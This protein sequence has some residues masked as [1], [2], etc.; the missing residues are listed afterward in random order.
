MKDT[1]GRISMH[2]FHGYKLN[3]SYVLRSLWVSL[4]ISSLAS[5]VG[6]SSGG[7]G[8]GGTP[9]SPPTPGLVGPW[10]GSISSSFAGNGTIA[11]D[12][13]SEIVRTMD[14]I[15]SVERGYASTL[16]GFWTA[17]F[18]G[19]INDNGGTFTG[20]SLD[21]MI[22]GTLSSLNGCPATINATV[23]EFTVEGTFSA[24]DCT[25]VDNGSFILAKQSEE[26]VPDI[27][28]V[29]TGSI[30][31]SAAGAG[32]VVVNINQI[33]LNFTGRITA[34]FAGTTFDTSGDIIGTSSGNSFEMKFSP[35]ASGDCP[36]NAFGTISGNTIS[37]SL[38]AFDCSESVSGSFTVVR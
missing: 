15:A 14:Q 23:T 1:N 32:T 29:Y 11:L 37:G 9:L 38:S 28:G 10:S 6:C 22:S 33:G 35:D 8:G 18:P 24:F 25:V 26:V 13:T 19:D 30:N 2:T 3:S 4:V 21:G 20:E 27:H 31:T 7:G 36:F 34:D 12:I 5:T 17:N 16:T